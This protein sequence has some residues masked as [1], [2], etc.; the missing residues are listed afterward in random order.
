MPTD[1]WPALPYNAWHETR[2]TLHMWLQ[3]VGKIALARAQ[4]LN[5]CWGAAL[6]VTTRGLSTRLLAASGRT[7]TIGFDFVGHQLRIDTSDGDVRT[8]PLTARSVADFYRE[9]MT[10]LK[11][12]GLDVNIWTMPV[13]LPPGA[14]AI[15][16]EDDTVH[17]SYDADYVNRFWRIVVEAERLLTSARRRFVGKASPAHVFWGAVDLALT[18]FNGRVADPLPTG[19]RFMC[20]AYSHEVI[21]HGFWPGDLRFPQAA[22]YAYLAPLKPGLEAARIEPDAAFYH[23]E[24]GEF[25]LPYEAVRRSQSPDADVLSFITTTYESAAAIADWDRKALEDDPCGVHSV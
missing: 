15:R 12:L 9:L 19:P 7:F 17:Q 14:P 11:D 22:F 10:A 18:R 1:R 16:F 2:D 21:S 24:L 5:H 3:I 6:Q 25:I 4:P 20:D 8:L 13:E 23:R